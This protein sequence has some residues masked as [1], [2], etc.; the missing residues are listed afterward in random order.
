[1]PQFRGLIAIIHRHQTGLLPQESVAES[2][3]EQI[4]LIHSNQHD[5]QNAGL[6]VANIT[7]EME[8]DLPVNRICFFDPKGAPVRGNTDYITRFL[9]CLGLVPTFEITVE[10]RQFIFDDVR[11][12]TQKTEN[13]LYL[14]VTIDSESSWKLAVDFSKRDGIT[15]LALPYQKIVK[16]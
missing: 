16:L 7:V 11:F 2:E 13:N 10:E 12:A 14:Y 8:R 4:V 15:P 3:H 5:P 6:I 1:M 9:R